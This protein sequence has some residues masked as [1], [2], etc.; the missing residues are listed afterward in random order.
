M[1]TRLFI[2][3][4]YHGTQNNTMRTIIVFGL[5]FMAQLCQPEQVL[6]QAATTVLL[7]FRKEVYF[8]DKKLSISILTNDESN[9]INSPPSLLLCLKNKTG[10]SLPMNGPEIRFD[11]IISESSKVTEARFFNVAVSGMHD[12]DKGPRYSGGFFSPEYTYIIDGFYTAMR[13]RAWEVSNGSPVYQPLKIGSYIYYFCVRFLGPDNIIY[14][15]PFKFRFK[16][17]GSDVDQNSVLRNLLPMLSKLKAEKGAMRPYFPPFFEGSVKTES[18]IDTVQMRTFYTGNPQWEK[19]IALV[20][21][22]HI[23]RYNGPRMLQ[24]YKDVFMNYIATCAQSGFLSLLGSSLWLPRGDPDF[25]RD[26]T[27]CYRK[28]YTS[29]NIPYNTNIRRGMIPTTALTK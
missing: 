19:H 12:E 7:P 2:L 26:L 1:R 21:A 3:I 8:A 5:V 14:S 11:S 18:S 22:L 28:Y 24:L 23:Y 9:S 20:M 27:N 4:D 25:D 6:C 15:F 13:H 16:M 29:T 17:T 10:I